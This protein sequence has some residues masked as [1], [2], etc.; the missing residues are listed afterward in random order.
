M[1]GWQTTQLWE[2]K[3]AGRPRE[4]PRLVFTTALGGLLDPHNVIRTLRRL[5]KK[6]GVRSFGY[7]TGRYT[8]I[9]NQLRAG[10]PLEVV[11]AI[12]GHAN[13]SITLDAYRDV[14]EDE[15]QTHTFDLRQHRA[16]VVAHAQ[17]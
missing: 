5:S 10:Q 14:L 11:S 12:A 2:R 3:Q 4:E 13:P 7:H 15:K 17:A 6:S 16:N 9:T 8:N 1:Q